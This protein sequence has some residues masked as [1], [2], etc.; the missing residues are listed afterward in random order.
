MNL[1]WCVQL[2]RLFFVCLCVGACVIYAAKSR[3]DPIF[4]CTS[5]GQGLAYNI[6]WHTQLGQTTNGKNI[7]HL[8]VADPG[9]GFVRFA[10]TPLTSLLY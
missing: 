2:L 10:R 1:C 4:Q 7:I 3:A 5:V 8:P 9:G 6:D